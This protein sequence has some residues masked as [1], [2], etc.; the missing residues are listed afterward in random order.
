MVLGGSALFA[1]A[2]G[3]GVPLLAVGASAGA[4]LPKAGPWMETVKRFFGVLLLGVAI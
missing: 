4:L 1:M 3:M 2:L